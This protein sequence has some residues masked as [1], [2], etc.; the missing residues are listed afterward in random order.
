MS[1][2]QPTRPAR[3]VHL[4]TVVY[5]QGER[6]YTYLYDRELPVGSLAVTTPSGD[7]YKLVKVVDRDPNVGPEGVN[8]K[9]AKWL[10]GHVDMEAYTARKQ[11]EARAAELQLRLDVAL[12]EKTAQNKYALLAEDPAYSG[13][14]AELRDLQA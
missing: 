9:N 1:E 12:R 3:E 6:P 7:G 4:I 11:R 10:V 13:L 5:T 2:D 8:A 14:L